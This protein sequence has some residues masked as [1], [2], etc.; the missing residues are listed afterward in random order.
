MKFQEP[1]EIAHSMDDT[2]VQHFSTLLQLFDQTCTRKSP[3][4]RI[5][6]ES[7]M[8]VYFDLVNLSNLIRLF[9]N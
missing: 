2:I 8:Q 1:G 3:I 9:F 4:K 7:N 6:L 5:I